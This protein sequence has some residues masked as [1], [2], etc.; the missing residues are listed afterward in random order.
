MS[1]TRVAVVLGAVALLA[2]ASRY[3]VVAAVLLVT[4]GLAVGL[5]ALG[6]VTLLPFVVVLARAEARGRSAAWWGAL[7]VLGL[8]LAGALLVL[9]G[10]GVATA[11]VAF[12]LAWGAPVAVGSARPGPAVLLAGRHE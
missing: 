8:L 3:D 10:P 9:G 11:V 12:V 5:L 6:S 2:L 4:A 1:R 7:Q